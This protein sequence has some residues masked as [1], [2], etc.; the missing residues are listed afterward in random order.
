MSA[1]RGVRSYACLTKPGDS[2]AGLGC[3]YV[4][5]VLYSIFIS[6]RL[7]HTPHT[8]D[9]MVTVQYM[10]LLFFS[11]VHTYSTYIMVAEAI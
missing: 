2:G 5:Y 1:G 4:E 10:S 11:N 8:R 6:T 9:T 7:I 3:S